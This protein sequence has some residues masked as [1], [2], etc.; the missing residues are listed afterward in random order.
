MNVLRSSSLLVV[1]AYKLNSINT[2]GK[3]YIRRFI[4]P[5]LKE[6]TRRKKKEAYDK[7][8]RKTVHHPRSGFLEWNYDAEIYAFNQRLKEK[9]DTDLL[10]QALTHRSYVIQEEQKQKQLGIEDPDLKMPDNKDLIKRGKT[11]TSKI[12]QLYLSSAL[13]RA[14]EECIRAFHDHLMLP[15]TLANSSSLIGTKDIILSEEYPPSQ[16]VLAETFLALVAALAESVDEIHA[17]KF[18]RDFL[19]ATLAE[20]DLGEIWSPENPLTILNDILIKE[21]RQPVEPRIIAQSGI[22]TVMP[23][24]QIGL[25]SNKEFISAGFEDS[26]DGAVH[27]AA[28]NALYKMFDISDSSKPMKFNLLIDPSVDKMNNLPLHKWCTENVQ[29][30]MQKN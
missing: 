17:T 7:Y 25:F 16:E 14:P 4:S 12:I 10:I 3:R 15:T 23:I 13:P 11:L 6:I 8:F 5:V 9:F 26:I 27:A 18:V 24:Y 19:I 30:L 22:N 21:G 20:K 1:Q 28:L 29:K 2:I